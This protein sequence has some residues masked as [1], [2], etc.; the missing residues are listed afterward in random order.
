VKN[1]KH[2]HTIYKI[3]EHNHHGKHKSDEEYYDDDWKCVFFIGCNI[4]VVSRAWAGQIQRIVV[5]F[6]LS[7]MLIKY[8]ANLAAFV[9]LYLV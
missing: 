5:K 8:N 2:T 4:V 7:T 9:I 1:V 6:A 3:I